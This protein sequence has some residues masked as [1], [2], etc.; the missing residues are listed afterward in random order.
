M[1]RTTKAERKKNAKQFYQ[2]ICNGGVQKAAIVIHRQASKTNPNIHRCQFITA[3]VNGPASD[4]VIAESVDG[5]TGCFYELVQSIQGNI[6][7]KGYFEDGFQDWFRRTM[8]MR[9]TWNDGLV[10]MVE[11]ARR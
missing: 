10:I 11:Y 4:V 9:I 7:Q 3:H 1:K 8:H 2:L 5:I 6:P